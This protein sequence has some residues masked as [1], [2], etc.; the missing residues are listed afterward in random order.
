[1]LQIL[2][3]IGPVAGAAFTSDARVR[4]LSLTGSTATGRA[5]MQAAARH[6]PRLAFELG[7]NAPFI[8]LPDADLALAASELVKLK[9]FCS[10]QVCV[11]ANRVF[12]PA[13]LEREFIGTLFGRTS[14]WATDSWRESMRGRSSMPGP[15]TA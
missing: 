7:G 14:A 15:A 5:L 3:A 13:S 6:L 12:V 4:V 2:P 10:G 8:V 9:L 11:T 1:V